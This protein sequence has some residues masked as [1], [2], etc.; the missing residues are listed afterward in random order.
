MGARLFELDVQLSRGRLVVSHFLPVLGRRGWLENDK[1]SFRWSS[2]ASCDPVVHDVVGLVPAECEILLDLKEREPARRFDLNQKISAELADRT[3]YRVSGGNSEDLDELRD[4]G[5]RTWRSIGR[6]SD[7]DRVLDAG[8]RLDEAVSVRHT[9]LDGRSIELLH[10]VVPMVVAWTVN[11]VA[12]GRELQALG[13]DG[14][15]SDS[16]SV[17]IA[18][19]AG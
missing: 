1:W 16:A 3:R 12:R 8:P 11:D 4:A 17:I 15:T 9:L 10:A 7:L 19:A 5:F 13:V 6:R 14:V 2:R 18:L